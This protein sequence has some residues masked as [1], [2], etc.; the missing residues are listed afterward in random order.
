MSQPFHLCTPFG[1]LYTE[2]QALS[3]QAINSVI[4]SGIPDRFD[5]F[6]HGE[7]K[8]V[9]RRRTGIVAFQR[10]RTRQYNVCTPC[11]WGPPRLM[12]DD[13][14]RLLL[15]TQE[16]VQIFDFM[17]GIAAAPVDQPNVWI[18]QPATI[19]IKGGPR[20]EQ[21]IA[22]PCRWDIYLHRIGTDRQ[23]R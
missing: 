23:L 14:F 20:I 21:H 4:G 11:C 12:D 8:A 7:V 17:E 15:G 9:S 6:L 16:A 22:A 19:K 13:G 10:C 5:G 1:E 18:G 2:A 3:E